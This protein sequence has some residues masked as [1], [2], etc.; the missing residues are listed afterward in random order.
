MQLLINQ[1]RNTKLAIKFFIIFILLGLGFLFMEAA[2]YKTIQSQQQ[3]L[4]KAAELKR[5]GDFVDKI[6]L[7]ILEANRHVKNFE[8]A[9]LPDDLSSFNKKMAEIDNHLIAIKKMM[10]S[11][12]DKNFI[13]KTKHTTE[14]YQNH[15]YASV[16]V[17]KKVGLFRDVD[18][19]TAGLIG[20]FVNNVID[21][22][23]LVVQTKDEKI[24]EKFIALRVAHDDYLKDKEAKTPAQIVLEHEALLKTISHFK[25]KKVSAAALKDEAVAVMQ[26]FLSW[27][28]FESL[29]V[30]LSMQA[31]P[32]AAYFLFSNNQLLFSFLLTTT[33]LFLIRAVSCFLRRCK[34]ANGCAVPYWFEHVV[35]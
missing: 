17:A 11:E 16:K 22:T 12:Q 9:Q 5:F 28:N 21:L 2:Y 30:L 29:F 8:M 32:V 1:F 26:S 19:G 20:T 18:A 3:S 24:V 10:R 33:A 34:H 4:Q 27:F 13:D 25:S 14:Q 7:N 23:K 6:H 31:F 15:F 35:V